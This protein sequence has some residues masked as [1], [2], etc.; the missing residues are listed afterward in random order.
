MI[1]KYFAGS[2]QICFSQEMRSSLLLHQSKEKNIVKENIVILPYSLLIE[3][4]KVVRKK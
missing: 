4:L 3:T 2:R 1:S